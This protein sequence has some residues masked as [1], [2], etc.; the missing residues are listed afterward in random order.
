MTTLFLL[1]NHNL[2]ASQK[3]DAF[4]SLNIDFIE[5]PPKIVKEVWSQVPADLDKLFF[6]LE[7]ARNW[8]NDASHPGDFLLVQGD[9]GAT[10]LMAKFAQDN[11]LIPIYSTTARIAVEKELEN[12][13]IQS[14]H[15]FTHVRYRRYGQ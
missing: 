8:L 3:A 11:R 9:F 6:Y 14:E 7:P 12:G 2:T 1:F 4:N 5:D 10:F 15:N 13:S